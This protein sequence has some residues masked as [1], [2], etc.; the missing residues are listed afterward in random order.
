MLKLKL[1]TVR[2]QINDCL[3]ANNEAI[4]VQ[5]AL[6]GWGGSNASLKICQHNSVAANLQKTKQR[7]LN[8][9]K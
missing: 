4:R 1:F 6:K 8:E 5:P 2:S 9:R 7:K 3:T